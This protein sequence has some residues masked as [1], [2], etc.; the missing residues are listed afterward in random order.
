EEEEDDEGD[1]V[2]GEGAGHEAVGGSADMYR[3]MN[4]GDWQV[5]QENWMDQQDEQWGRINT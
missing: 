4:Q 5:R 1:E 3:H 2:A